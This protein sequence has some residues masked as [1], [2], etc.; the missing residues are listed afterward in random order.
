MSDIG[1]TP[2][3]GSSRELE[4]NLESFRFGLSFDAEAIEELRARDP[5]AHF[6]TA[7]LP[8]ESLGDGITMFDNEMNELDN[9]SDWETFFTETNFL[10]NWIL[11][12]SDILAHGSAG[13]II[14][15][16][17]ELLSF[18]PKDI[19]L[20]FDRDTRKI[21]KAKCK[22]YFANANLEMQEHIVELVGDPELDTFIYGIIKK[23][24]KTFQGISTLEKVWDIIN[25]L[26]IVDFMASLY[27]A[28]V[29]AGIKVVKAATTVE[30]E[31]DK[32]LQNLRDLSYKQGIVL[33]LE[34]DFKIYTGEGSIDFEKLKNILYDSL[35]SATGIPKTKWRGE[36]PGELSAGKINR[37]SYIDILVQ[38]QD[39]SM[40]LLKRI[41][42]LISGLRS[43][44]LPDDFIVEYNYKEEP[45]EREQSEIE[46]IKANSFNLKANY[47]TGNEIREQ[48]KLE[49][50][51]F[52]TGSKQ[53]P[54]AFL[55]KDDKFTI[56]LGDELTDE[57][58][59]RTE[60]PGSEPGSEPEPEETESNNFESESEPESE[61]A[62]T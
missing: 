4:R 14:F 34:D 58:T 43:L 52:F 61:P 19:E 24:A 26:W 21:T 15:E 7:A 28:R 40:F 31:Q 50:L 60:Q 25:A 29:G 16:S 30:K 54:L 47:M 33:Q 3:S 18:L 55:L 27:A 36:V 56:Q 41:L 53:V 44:P 35:A 37:S 10:D 32:I 5:V 45:T 12:V 46:N 8:Q 38:I 11:F 39:R 23:G 9:W 1:D 42:R 6:L 49:E 48:E 62:S 22:E 20:F 13:A 59:I 17:G 2:K 51:D 57:S